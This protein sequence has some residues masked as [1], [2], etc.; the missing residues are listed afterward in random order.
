MSR[1]I[2]VTCLAVLA[3]ASAQAQTPIDQLAKPPGD[4]AH[5]IIQSVGGKHGDSWLWAMPDGTRMNR[6]SFNLRGQV[7]EL[8]SATKAG[9]DGMPASIV[10]RGQTPQGDAGETFAVTNGKATWK[11][12]VDAG[13]ANYKVP[14]FYSS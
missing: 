9:S 6:E 4:A 12:P 2:L 11:S 8:D 10:I 5:F 3:F 7:F 1:K 13:G 14:A